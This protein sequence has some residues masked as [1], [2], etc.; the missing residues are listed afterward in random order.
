[1]LP[2]RIWILALPPYNLCYVNFSM[3]QFFICKLDYL[4]GLLSV[5]NQLVQC[6]EQGLAEG[7]S[8]TDSLTAC[9]CLNQSPEF[10]LSLSLPILTSTLR[11]PLW[12]P[13]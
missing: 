1:M 13:P 10:P 2:F 3:P 9:P 5:L 12:V 6:L 11:A 4:L 7:H 8:L